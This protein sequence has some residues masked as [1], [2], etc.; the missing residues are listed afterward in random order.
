MFNLFS[1][2]F[3]LVTR[4]K[5]IVEDGIAYTIGETQEVVKCFWQ[6][7]MNEQLT[8]VGGNIVK[9]TLKKGDATALVKDTNLDFEKIV[10]LD[11][12]VV[13]N[14]IK[15]RIVSATKRP[16]GFIHLELKR[17]EG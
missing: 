8:I 12:Y 6:N 13:K 5:H 4:Q 9:G 3:L 16:R 2:E 10:N 11:H 14:N 1:D 7:V 17:L 15:Y